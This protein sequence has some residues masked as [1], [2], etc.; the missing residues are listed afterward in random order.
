M[1]LYLY[2]IPMNKKTVLAY[3]K[4]V[5]DNGITGA[6]ASTEAVDRDGDVLVQAGWQL[7]NFLKNPVM[8]WSHNPFELPI[9]KVTKIGV[10]GTQ[11]VFDAEFAIEEN[12]HAK[13]VFDLMKGGFLNTF[14]VGFI[15]KEHK[16]GKITKMELLE[17]SVV[18]I[19]ANQ[20]AT[21]S[22][23]YKSFMQWELQK[24]GRVISEKNRTLLRASIDAM[25][26]S[27]AALD[28]LLSATEPEEKK[29]DEPD[30][31]QKA[32]PKMVDPVMQALKVIDKAAEYLLQ[33]EKSKS[34][35]GEK[36]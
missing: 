4:S 19:P 24:A 34:K 6:I 33:A 35:G 26:G 32:K 3:T 16:D 7:D 23:E 29:T 22:R 2:L 10:E 14:S 25:K 8:L 1:R 27:I 17:I 21:V 9:G 5:K 30:Q 12:D 28:E 11:L 36:K 15:P 20:E 13:K 18:P 31:S